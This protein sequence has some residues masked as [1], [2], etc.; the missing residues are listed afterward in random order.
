M[1]EEVG[2]VYWE[3]L[4]KISRNY[5]FLFSY[6]TYSNHFC[7]FSNALFSRETDREN[8]QRFEKKLRCSFIY[9]LN[10][11]RNY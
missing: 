8:K 11:Y 6:R 2:E 10:K 4:I 5:L 1:H 7:V 9:D 3:F